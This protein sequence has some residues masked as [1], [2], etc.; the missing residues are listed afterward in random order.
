M[1]GT[2]NCVFCNGKFTCG[3]QK[4]TDKSGRTV[5]KTCLD[6]ANAQIRLKELESQGQ[7]K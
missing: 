1:A 5:H 7:I 6:L 3:C 4:T 2:N